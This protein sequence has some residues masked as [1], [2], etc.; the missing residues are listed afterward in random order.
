MILAEV[1]SNCFVGVKL[2]VYITWH[3][4]PKMTEEKK[5][6]SVTDRERNSVMM[7]ATANML[8]WAPK[9][10]ENSRMFEAELRSKIFLD[11]TSAL[12]CHG[13]Q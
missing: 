3:L 6:L 8:R 13:K 12:R 4:S 9:I 10:Q 1:V 2:I 5:F 7:H 11:F